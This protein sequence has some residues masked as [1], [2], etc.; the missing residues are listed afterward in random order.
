MPDYDILIRNARL[1]D[2]TGRPS[3]V[4]DL[5][6]LGDRIAAIGDLGGTS[7]DQ[8]IDADGMV[9]SPGFIDSHCHDD[10]AILDMP[11][12]EPKVS[13]GVT[14]VINGNCGVSIA[15]VL[16]DRPKAPPPLNLFVGEDYRHFPD[17]DAYFSALEATP[18]AVNSACLCGHS[19]LR[20][21]VMDRLDRAATSEE[22]SRMCGLLEQALNAGA[23]G[24]ST[25]LYYPPATAAPTEEVIEIS[26]TLGGHGGLYVTHM[27]NEEDNVIQSLEET[28]RIG[29]D[30]QVPVVV[31][32]H[33]CV[34]QPNHG[35]S[36]ITLAMIDEA[37]KQQSVSLDAYPYAAS[38]TI[39]QPERVAKCARVMITWSDVMP[40]ASG[41]DLADIA[42]ELGCSDEEAAKRLLPGG[43]VYFQMSED[44]V[45]RILSYP[46]TMI[47]SDG[48]V[49]DKHPHPRAWGTFPRVLGHYSRDEGLFPL[50]TAVHKMTALT[51]KTFGLRDRGTLRVANFADLVLFNPDTI[52]DVADF[53][54][55]CRAAMGIEKVFTNG[56]CT[57]ANRKPTGARPGRPL[58]RV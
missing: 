39:L 6:V 1:I 41:R 30:A 15:P 24:L 54:D 16:P 25:G 37:R 48:I 34:S 52:I 4:G 53:A 31:S 21:A 23:I 46:D 55:P 51:A 28:F 45:Q 29:R 58:R 7:A 50:E 43:A 20:H 57:W 36:K 27:R 47:G 26:K 10:R 17:F 2:G 38:S 32:H 56:I 13:Q 35:K 33:K 22:I 42:R 18:P 44:D 5:A 49:Q 19:N 9:L 40:D 3:E 8:V 14:T 11:L 12:L